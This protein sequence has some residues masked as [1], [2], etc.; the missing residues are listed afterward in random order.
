MRVIFVE[1][2]QIFYIT[3]KIIIKMSAAHFSLLTLVCIIGKHEKWK[4]NISRQLKYPKSSTIR[5][6]IG[7]FSFFEVAL[8]KSLKIIGQGIIEYSAQA[9]VFSNRKC[10]LLKQLFNSKMFFEFAEMKIT[11]VP[12]TDKI[13]NV[14]GLISYRLFILKCFTYSN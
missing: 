3:G 11:F 7:Y 4:N 1:L 13:F 14:H 2:V 5:L 8:I 12:M 6:K 10:N 9:L